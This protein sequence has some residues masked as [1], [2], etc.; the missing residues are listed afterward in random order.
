MKLRDTRFT[1]F[2]AGL[3]IVCLALM[4][5]PALSAPIG[6]TYNS[7]DLGGQLLTG[8]GSTWR[9]GV[10]S[11]FPHVSHAQSWNGSGLG[12]QWEISCPSASSYVSVV[13]NRVGGIGTIVYTTNYSGGTFTFFP[14]G[15]PWGDGNG[16]LNTTSEITTVQY[17]LISGVSTPV[18]SRSNINTSGTFSDGCTLGFAIANGVGVCETPVC[19]K[20]ANYPAFL[21]G[22][23][24]PASSTAQFG[25]WGDVMAISMNI[26]CVTPTKPSTWGKVKTLYR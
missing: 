18:A 17:I 12:T 3:S 6:G 21:D 19:T 10:N 22:T 5:V 24:N 16:T 20:P 26:G 2:V 25:A 8:R 13:D 7:T 11:G 23:C 14:G 1:S 15:W 9:P 4:A